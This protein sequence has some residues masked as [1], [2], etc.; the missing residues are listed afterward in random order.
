MYPN[1]RLLEKSSYM[2]I[3]V[4]MLILCGLTLYPFIYVLAYS[5][6]DGTASSSRIITILPRNPTMENYYAVFSNNLIINAFG[7]SVARTVS[8]TILHLMVT[9]LA[10]YAISKN[11]LY[12]RK[13]LMFYFMIPMF[14]AGGLIPSYILINKLHLM[15]NFLVYILP[16]MFSTFNMIIVSTYLRG[17]PESLEES[18]KLDGAGDMK[19]FLWIVVPLSVPVFVT[20]ALFVG[21]AQWNAWFDAFLYMTNTKLHP[22]QTLL[23]K[24]MFEAQAKDFQQM[25]QMSQEKTNVTPEAIKMSTLIVSV[26][27]AICV[28]PFLQKY[29][30]K[31][32]TMGAVKA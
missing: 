18:A 3:V 7:I 11:D 15:N 8:G 19:I 28:Y 23:Y 24:I 22:L 9:G 13:I 6:S 30:V 2:L 21:V 16:G 26:V 5:L 10:A 17:L 32:V 20:I 29:F 27:P 14:V 12:G 31:G 1:H 25:V 4:L